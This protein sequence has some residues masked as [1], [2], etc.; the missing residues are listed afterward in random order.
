MISR[1]FLNPWGVVEKFCYPAHSERGLRSKFSK[2]PQKPLEPKN[3]KNS[4]N[5]KTTG[6]RA[7]LAGRGAVSGRFGRLFRAAEVP[8]TRST[9]R[10]PLAISIQFRV[11]CGNF[12]ALEAETMDFDEETAPE[13]AKV[14]HRG[15]KSAAELSVVPVVPLQLEQPDPP[16][17]LSPEE[18]KTWRDAVD[19][20]RPGWFTPATLPLLELY[21]VQAMVADTVARALRGMPVTDRHFGI[22]ARMHMRASQAM[23]SLGTKLRLCPSSSRATKYARAA[24]TLAVDKRAC[25]LERVAAE[26]ARVRQPDDQDVERAARAALRGLLQAPA[27]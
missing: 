14:T 27:P 16:A 12:L 15:R 17:H 2:R 5:L 4:K 24:A 20:M 8:R 21:C 13:V 6:K 10:F 9:A 7:S 23:T 25:F 18:A 3:P 26:L 19:G 11:R 22:L 1:Q